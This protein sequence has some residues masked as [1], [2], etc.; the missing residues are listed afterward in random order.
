MT[1]ERYP[2]ALP[3]PETSPFTRVRG[4]RQS[5]IPRGPVSYS[6]LERSFRGQQ[7][8]T[9]LFGPQDAATFRSWWETTLFRGALWFVA[10]WP[11][12]SGRY[13]S[14]VVRKFITPPRWQHVGNGAWRVQATTEVLYSKA[15]SVLQLSSL[16]YPVAVADSMS[17]A[18][19]AVENLFYAYSEIMSSSSV[20]L[21]ST[22]ASVLKTYSMGY[23]IFS[24]DSI[25][26]DG[27]LATV[28]KTYST[29]Y[30]TMS[31]S[32]VALNGTYTELLVVYDIGYET[33]S[34]S[35]MALDGT[36]VT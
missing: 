3:S 26:L 13:N 9:F 4:T 10:R 25:A 20:A 31:S 27:T 36:L 7:E 19:E 21:D 14:E 18:S 8:V 24:S 33:M 35:C 15:I 23:E 22:L 16:T 1:Y 12:P 11:I 28:L 34:S 32:S 17:S 6:L 2:N 5:D 30:E 29:G